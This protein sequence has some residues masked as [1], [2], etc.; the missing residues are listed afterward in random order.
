[1][2]PATDMM[3]CVNVIIELNQRAENKKTP[4]WQQIDLLLFNR[5]TVTND[6]IS[7]WNAAG[8]ALTCPGIF[9]IIL[10]LGMSFKVKLNDFVPYIL[11]FF[12][13]PMSEP[14]E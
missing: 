5:L 11:S 12:F 14:S 13:S 7:I 2:V 4:N 8:D 1:M 10:H 6:Q 9:V 3:T